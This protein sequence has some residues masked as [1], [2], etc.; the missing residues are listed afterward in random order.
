MIDSSP[1]LQNRT[2]R[3]YWFSTGPIRDG[4]TGSRLSRLQYTQPS[5]PYPDLMS[6][7]ESWCLPSTPATATVEPPDA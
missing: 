6:R 7:L 2:R 4:K 1:R 5:D 3:D